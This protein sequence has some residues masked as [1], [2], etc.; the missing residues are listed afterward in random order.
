MKSIWTVLNQFWK[1][2]LSDGTGLNLFCNCQLGNVTCFNQFK[3]FLQK[4]SKTC[5]RLNQFRPV[6]KKSS[7]SCNR[8]EPVST[9]SNQLWKYPLG[10]EAGLNQYIYRVQRKV[11][12]RP[13]SLQPLY[14]DVYFQ[15]QAWFKKCKDLCYVVFKNQNSILW[16]LQKLL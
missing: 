8:F 1:R 6:L 10:N 3:P 4:S 5:N 14:A 2:P 15:I 11:V 13:F 9:R 7:K 16:K 12:R